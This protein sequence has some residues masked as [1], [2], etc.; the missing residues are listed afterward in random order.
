MTIKCRRSG[1]YS[2]V[3]TGTV[4][5]VVTG[6]EGGTVDI[7]FSTGGLYRATAWRVEISKTSF[8]DMAK[9]MVAANSTY[10]IRAFGAALASFDGTT[11]PQ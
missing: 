8:E 10:A 4:D 1:A 7:A 5:G 3:G 11:Q 6:Y 9:A 2:G